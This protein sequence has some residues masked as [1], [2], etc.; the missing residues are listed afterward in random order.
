MFRIMYRLLLTVVAGSLAI[1]SSASSQPGPTVSARVLQ[2]ADSLAAREFAKDSVGS[3]TV[4]IVTGSKLAWTKS[5]G[6]GRVFHTTLGHDDRSA[7]D[8][9]APLRVRDSPRC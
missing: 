2:V 7:V 8:S 9:L 6:K 3:I 1:A 4:G 5:Y